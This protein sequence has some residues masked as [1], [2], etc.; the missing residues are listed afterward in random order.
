MRKTIASTFAFLA[1]TLSAAAAFAEAKTDADAKITYEVPAGFTTETKDN[2]TAISE[3]KN[4]IAFFVVKT[5]AKDADKA[6]GEL[7][8]VLNALF[9]DPKPV[10]G[11]TK[12][13]YNGMKAVQMKATATY[14]GKPVNVTL[15]FLETPSGKY[16]VVVGAYLTAKKEQL[17]DTFNK[18]YNSFKPVT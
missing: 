7:E 4:E 8:Q 1:L 9:K 12:S 17:K 6:M 14:E 2:I 16:V 11:P 3:P 5:N 15:R 18:F 10:S 13:T